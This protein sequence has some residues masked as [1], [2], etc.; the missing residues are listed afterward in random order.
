MLT[1]LGPIQQINAVLT[2]RT[3]APM[4]AE[5]S[6]SLGET[7]RNTHDVDLVVVDG[8]A[9]LRALRTPR[10]SRRSSTPSA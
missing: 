4:L 1:L 5:G 2:L 8:F 7:A 9:G 10:S 6:T 3:I